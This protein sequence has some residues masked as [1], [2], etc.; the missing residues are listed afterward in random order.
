MRH[1]LRRSRA[2]WPSPGGTRRGRAA[3]CRPPAGGRGAWHPGRL[4]TRAGSG[5]Y[6]RETASPRQ[7][8]SSM[9]MLRA[10]PRDIRPTPRRQGG[11]RRL[12]HIPRRPRPSATNGAG[13]GHTTRAAGEIALPAPDRATGSA[14]RSRRAPAH[15]A[16]GPRWRQTKNSSGACAGPPH[17]PAAAGPRRGPGSRRCRHHPTARRP[18]FQR[19]RRQLVKM[20]RRLAP[21]PQPPPAA[22][23]MAAHGRLGNRHGAQLGDAQLVARAGARRGSASRPQYRRM[24]DRGPRALTAGLKICQSV[25]RIYITQRRPKCQAPAGPGHD[26]PHYLLGTTSLRSL[27]ATRSRRYNAGGPA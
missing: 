22:P 23:W 1:L 13:L 15:R 27:T 12:E 17:S 2:T 14:R 8:P 19:R 18:R 16:A 20:A 6:A 5:R 3:P 10:S 7:A 24:S 25:H 9:G 11:A 4:A 21:R 26:G